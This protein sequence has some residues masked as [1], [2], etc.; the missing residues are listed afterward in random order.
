MLSIIS[1]FRYNKNNQPYT[2][3][4]KPRHP[5]RDPFCLLN[6]LF[7]RGCALPPVSLAIIPGNGRLLFVQALV[8]PVYVRLV[9]SRFFSMSFS[10]RRKPSLTF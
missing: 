4:N 6:F 10:N 8:Y 3:R 1:P 2:Q 9:S 5:V 7:L